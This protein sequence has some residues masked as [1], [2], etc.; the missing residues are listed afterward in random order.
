[1]QLKQG[2]IDIGALQE[3]KLTEY[4]YTQGGRWDT[5][6]NQWCQRSDTAVVLLSSRRGCWGIKDVRVCG[7]WYK[8]C[9]LCALIWDQVLICCMYSHL[10]MECIYGAEGGSGANILNRG[11][12][13]EYY[14]KH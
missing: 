3:M 13:T 5:Q 6:F 14:R 12:G 8:F 1:M 10:D 9:D 4:V 11:N 2:N 7:V